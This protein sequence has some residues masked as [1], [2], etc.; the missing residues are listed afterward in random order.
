MGTMVGEK[1]GSTI[2]VSVFSRSLPNKPW[3][4]DLCWHDFQTQAMSAELWNHCWGSVLCIHTVCD[5]ADALPSNVNTFP[6]ANICAHTRFSLANAIP[7]LPTTHMQLW[8]ATHP[9]PRQS[10]RGALSHD[11]WVMMTSNAIHDTTTFYSWPNVKKHTPM[12]C[13]S[14]CRA[15]LK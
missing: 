3:V 4:P 8:E 14:Q 13:D 15:P 6:Y 9:I 5:S 2:E 12:K 10:R 7:Q 1:V 11:R